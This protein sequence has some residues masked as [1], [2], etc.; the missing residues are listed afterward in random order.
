[1]DYTACSYWCLLLDGV[2]RPVQAVEVVGSDVGVCAQA[3]GTWV[4][5][6]LSSPAFGSGSVEVHR[7]RPSLYIP[8]GELFPRLR[9]EDFAP[10]VLERVQKNN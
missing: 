6:Q 2:G 8:E 9:G 3:V 4:E 10:L 7:L 1:M 5:A